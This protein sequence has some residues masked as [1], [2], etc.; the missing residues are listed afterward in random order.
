MNNSRLF[1]VEIVAK[2][3]SGPP[4]GAFLF[5]VA[6]GLPFYLDSSTFAVAAILILAIGGTYRAEEEAL[7]RTSIRTRDRGGA[8]LAVA[9]PLASD[10][11]AHAG[12]PE[13]PSTAAFAIFPLY[14][15]EILRVDEVGFGALLAAGAVGSLLGT[16]ASD[17]LIRRTGPAPLLIG[18]VLSGVIT[19]AVIGFTSEAILVGAMFGVFAFSGIVWNV[20]T[21]SLRQAIIPDRLLGRANSVYRFF[22]WG[23]MP[24]GAG[25]GVCSPTPSDCSRRGSLLRLPQCC[26][27][28]PLGRFSAPES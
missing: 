9:T 5:A 18:T 26:C 1:A 27:W 21:V 25:P 2:E 8:S 12:G 19:N 15:L 14:A 11:C 6:A 17:A 23:A 4:I 16:L 10:A 13:P 20:I 28:S 7:R 22:G 3:F 24:I